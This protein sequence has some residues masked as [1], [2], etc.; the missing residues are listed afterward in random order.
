M[1]KLYLVLFFAGI[2]IGCDSNNNSKSQ[3]SSATNVLKHDKAVTVTGIVRIGKSRITSGKIEV[4]DTKGTTLTSTHFKNNPT[5]SVEIPA[6]TSYPVLLSV[7]PG[8]DASKQTPLK[9]VVMNPYS[10]DQVITRTTTAIAEKALSL[11]GYTVKNMMKATR[12]TSPFPDRDTTVEGFNG[13][14][15]TKFGGWH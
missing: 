13:D 12:T 14:P 7:Y 2:L 10:T 15:T 8:I 4:A 3:G 11:G 1:K 6:G 9:V 5:F